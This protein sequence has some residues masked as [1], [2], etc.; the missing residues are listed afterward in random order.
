VDT[1]GDPL[2]TEGAEWRTFEQQ[3]ATTAAGDLT[4][5]A[6]SYS[7]F[8]P[9][10]AVY[11]TLT[12]DP[13]LISVAPGAANT[14]VV[15]S[16]VPVSAPPAFAN[17]IRG[18]KLAP[19]KAATPILTGQP[20][21]WLL[22]LIP[23]AL[24][25]VPVAYQRQQMHRAQNSDKLRRQQAAKEANK[26]LQAAQKNGQEVHAAAGQIFQDYLAAKLNRA[27]SGLT[28]RELTQTLQDQGVSDGALDEMQAFLARCEY[29]RYAPAGSADMTLWTDVA[30]LIGKL[31]KEIEIGD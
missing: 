12:T 3:T 4:I 20:I 27:V 22:W 28:R 17:D 8:D 21:F 31:E 16:N 15:G 30:A 2:W 29:G 9:D 6:L 25:A 14:A 13:I 10:T 11:E 5:P 23:L 26:A 1:A 18:L 19:E 24:V 7:Y